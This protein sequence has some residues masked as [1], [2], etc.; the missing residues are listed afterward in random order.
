MG[1]CHSQP[2][3]QESQ[4][5]LLYIAHYGAEGLRGAWHWSFLLMKNKSHIDAMAY[6]VIGSPGTYTYTPRPTK[7]PKKSQTFQGMVYV[8]S[9]PTNRDQQFEDILASVPIA[10]GVNAGW[11]CQNWIMDALGRL[12]EGGFDV[13][14]MDHAELLRRLDAEKKVKKK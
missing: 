1:T 8:G 12:Y 3:A 2:Q 14:V 9:I 10:N 5:F 7:T 13:E 4:S 11:N 6:H